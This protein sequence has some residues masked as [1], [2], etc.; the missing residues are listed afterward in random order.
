MTDFV[1][2]KYMSSCDSESTRNVEERKRTEEEVGGL[3][4]KE[5]RARS[6]VHPGAQEEYD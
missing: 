2:R 1:F 3:F 6:L 5:N 4:F